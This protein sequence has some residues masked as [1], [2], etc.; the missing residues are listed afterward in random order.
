MFQIAGG[1]L[2]AVAV[3]TVLGI[4]AL[5]A[6]SRFNSWLGKT[7][8]IATLPAVPSAEPIIETKIAVI[9]SANVVGSG[10]VDE[11]AYSQVLSRY[12]QRV[13]PE[14]VGQFE[15]TGV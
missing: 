10:K 9:H 3:L 1:I 5:V 2:I 7:P 15:S 6:L 13:T 12:N 14:P 4:F 8:E 11:D